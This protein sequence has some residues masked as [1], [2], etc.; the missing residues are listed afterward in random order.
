MP[1]WEDAK[2][3]TISLNGVSV[4]RHGLIFSE[5]VAT[6]SSMFFNGFQACLA[7]YLVDFRSKCALRGGKSRIPNR[8][9][10]WPCLF[11]RVLIMSD[12][13]L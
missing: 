7:Q 9:F 6:G 11:S 4:T 13:D 10:L 3:I 8:C 12:D 5:D 1:L 2:T